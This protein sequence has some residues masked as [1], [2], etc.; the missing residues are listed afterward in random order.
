MTAKNTILSIIIFT[1]DLKLNFNFFK[2]R[3]NYIFIHKET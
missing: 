2:A 1:Y 3:N